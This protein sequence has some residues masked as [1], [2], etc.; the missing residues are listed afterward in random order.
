MFA[1]QTRYIC[2]RQILYNF[3]FEKFRYDINSFSRCRK[4]TYR[5]KG[6]I[7]C[8]AHIE[9][10]AG[11]YI[12]AECSLEHSANSVGFFDIIYI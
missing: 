6:H 12:D 8:E 5:A 4:A 10:S 9:N 3:S 1:L 7:E 11:I 2:Q